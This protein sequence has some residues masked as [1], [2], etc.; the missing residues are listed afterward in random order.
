MN[1]KVLMVLVIYYSFISLIFILGGSYLTGFSTNVNL[2]N[3]ALTSSEIDQGGL[4]GTG[5]SFT[6]FFTLVTFGIG[7]PS[8]TPS[9]FMVI[10]ALF[11]TCM[12]I[13]AVGFVISSIWNG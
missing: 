8:D 5:I 2:N 11:Q 9:W 4:F 10:F 7:L 12:T 6:R 3:S 1:L 13:F